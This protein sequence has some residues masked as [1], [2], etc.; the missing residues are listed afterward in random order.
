MKQL[1]SA[2]LGNKN[3]P[4]VVLATVKAACGGKAAHP[5]PCLALGLLAA[6]TVSVATLVQLASQ[7]KF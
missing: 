5:P 2:F 3:H 6:V 4:Q 1:T 7:E